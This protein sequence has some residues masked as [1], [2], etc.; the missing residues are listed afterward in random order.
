MTYNEVFARILARDYIRAQQWAQK[1]WF[2][3]WLAYRDGVR[4]RTGQNLSY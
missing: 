1:D 2:A 4:L 3:G